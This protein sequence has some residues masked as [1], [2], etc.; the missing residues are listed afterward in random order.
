M[1]TNGR[2]LV[3]FDKHNILRYSKR[4][5]QKN[6]KLLQKHKGDAVKILLRLRKTVL[7]FAITAAFLLVP[8]SQTEAATNYIAQAKKNKI[9]TGKFVTNEKGIRYQYKNKTYAKNKWHLIDGK[10]YY[11]ASDTYAETGWFTYKKNTYYADEKGVIAVSKWLTLNGRKYRFKS[12]GIRAT[13]EWVKVSKKYY[14]FESNGVM[15]TNKQV[16][17]GGK[18]YYV[19]TDGARKIN[20]WVTIKN[21]R[22]FFGK[23]GV[24]YQNKWVKYKGKYYYLAKNGVMSKNKWVGNYYVDGNGARKTNCYMDG[25]YLDGTGKKMKGTKNSKKY[26][27]AGD[28]RTVGM[29]TAISVSKTKFIGKVSMGYSW[30]SSTAG[31]QVKQYLAGN[32]KLKV[33][34]AFGIN[35]LGNI[36][37]YISYYKSLIKQFPDAKFY[38]LSVNPVNES[39]ASRA[40]YT[41]KNS[42]IKSFNSKLKKAFG[43]KY[44]NTYTWLTKNGFSSS[45]GIHYTGDTYKKLYNYIVKKIG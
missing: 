20:C 44:L 32:P 39:L 9:S 31:P 38:F 27:F 21:K 11:F 18:Y 45:D 4:K 41:I 34:F 22:Y 40:G 10:I 1:S 29:D 14:Y 36:S 17:H 25:Y 26:L 12:N 3:I 43:S 37:R 16:S 6:Y 13:K 5:L 15:A 42:A 35:D 33:V 19:G 28:S 23:D 24:R 7:L 2:K 30:L 8:V